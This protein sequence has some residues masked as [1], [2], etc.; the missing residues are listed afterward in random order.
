MAIPNK[1]CKRNS[2]QGK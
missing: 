2:A 1:Q